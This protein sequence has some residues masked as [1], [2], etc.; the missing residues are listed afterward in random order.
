MP[1]VN[2]YAPKP[3]F[4][5]PQETTRTT[6]ELVLSGTEAKLPNIKMILSHAGCTIAFLAPR[7][8]SII[9][10]IRT[11]EQVQ[12]DIA[13]FYFDT[14]LSSAKGQLL[15]LLEIAD[16]SHIVF[17]SDV[18]YAPIEAASSIMMKIDEFFC[19]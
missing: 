11:S 13:S 3:L 14:A 6:A 7:I 4:D 5:Y 9:T 8:C 18:P 16:S 12:Q 1:I 19:T 10:G 2:Q 15:T 17:G